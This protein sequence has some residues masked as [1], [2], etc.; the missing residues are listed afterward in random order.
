MCVNSK[1]GIE[2][3]ENVSCTILASSYK[4]PPMIFGASK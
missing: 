1:M 4:E 2:T 3:W